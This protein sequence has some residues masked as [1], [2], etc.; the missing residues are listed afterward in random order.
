MPGA[1]AAPTLITFAGVGAVMGVTVATVPPDAQVIASTISLKGTA[2]SAK[3][4]HRKNLDA[5]LGC[6]T[7]HANGV[8]RRRSDDSRRRA[9]CHVLG[10]AKLLAGRLFS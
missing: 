1:E 4:S 7:C 8:V 10:V 2:A 3:R 6:N 5:R 9:P